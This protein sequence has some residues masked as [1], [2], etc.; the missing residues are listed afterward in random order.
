MPC[1]IRVVYHRPGKGTTRF[2]HRL[3]RRTPDVTILLMDAYRGPDV[4][5]DG[6]TMLASG[7]A[8]LW[9]VF[10][11]TWYDIG[12]FFDRHGSWTGWYTN[13][14]RPVE[15]GP[16]G[17]YFFDL[18]LDLWQPAGGG[19]PTW[20]DADEYDAAVGRGLL[21]REDRAGAAAAR[22]NVDRAVRSGA[23]P[24][25]SVPPLSLEDARREAS[26][27]SA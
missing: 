16:D 11:D 15:I 12:R 3:V 6:Q 23:W 8:G 18:F 22:A 5:H 27:A 20:L 14:C 7:G 2:V 19:A 26:G 9:Y 1:D 24:P 17:W 25:S 13:L 10:P 4:I 21:S